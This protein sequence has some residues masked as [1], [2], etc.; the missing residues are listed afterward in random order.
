MEEPAGEESATADWNP[1]A[2]VEEKP[3]PPVQSVDYTEAQ[4]ALEHG[5]LD[6]AIELYTR[7]VKSGEHID[8]TINDLNKAL[9]RHPVDVGIW[10][11]LGDAYS[12]A[13]K[14]QEALDAYTKAED[15]L[16]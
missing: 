11:L 14:I 13:D 3:L 1:P 9:D 4:S 5:K 8:E 6:E 2:P 7:L 16:Q 15:L 12:K 10:Q